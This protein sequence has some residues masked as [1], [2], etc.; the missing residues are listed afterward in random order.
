[1]QIRA[2]LYFYTQKGIDKI[3]QIE[4]VAVEY[5]LA[6]KLEVHGKLISQLKENE[7]RS[8]LGCFLIAKEL[9]S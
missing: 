3:T 1:M 9:D 4:S 2:L 5:Y 6:P 7:Y 8:V